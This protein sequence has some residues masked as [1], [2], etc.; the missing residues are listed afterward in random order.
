MKAKLPESIEKFHAHL[1]ECKQCEAHPFDLCPVGDRLIRATAKFPRRPAQI[2]PK[3]D[4]TSDG[5]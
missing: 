2:F 1:D 3:A 5:R 4:K